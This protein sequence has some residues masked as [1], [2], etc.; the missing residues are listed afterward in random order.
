MTVFSNLIDFSVG[1]INRI[2]RWKQYFCLKYLLN[3]LTR[4]TALMTVP[5]TDITKSYAICQNISVVFIVMI[6]GEK[7]SSRM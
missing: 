3:T 5:F 1:E 6:L 7:L 4:K 2:D